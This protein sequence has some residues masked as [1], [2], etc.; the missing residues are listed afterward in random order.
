MTIQFNENYI[1]SFLNQLLNTPSPSGYTHHVM[2]LIRKEAEK[3]GV[4]IEWNA[5]G[6]AILTLEG[7]ETDHTVALSAHVDTLG[8]MVR[9]ITAQGTLRLTSVG[10]F[11][12]NSIE[13]EYCLI[14]T[15]SGQTYTG[16]ILSSHPSVHVYDDARSFERKE[17][18]M[19][20][21]IDELVESKE[22]VLQLGI[23]VGDFISFEARPVVTPSGFIKSRHLDDKASVAALFGLLESSVHGGWKPRHTVKLLIS[24]YEEVGHGAAYIP[25]GISEMIA[26]D[27]GC[28]GED[29]SCKETD[30]PSVPKTPQALTTIT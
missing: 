9:S 15:R 3:L 17:S 2:E 8:A 13:N 1:M 24:N 29:L 20:V 14:H 18:H 30:V 10:G 27:M 22:D 4:P 6:G 11:M 5:K 23:S 19:E 12:M 25:E 28:I 7:E 16:T 26:V 21:R